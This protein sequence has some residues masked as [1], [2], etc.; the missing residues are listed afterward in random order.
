MKKKC[1]FLS[2]LFNLVRKTQV[3]LF[4]TQVKTSL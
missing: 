2:Q 3:E 4:D 1:E